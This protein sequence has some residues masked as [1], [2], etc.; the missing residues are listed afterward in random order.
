M[1]KLGLE[2]D[3]LT[4]SIVNT[5]SEKDFP[6]ASSGLSTHKKLSEGKILYIETDH[7]DHGGYIGAEIT[8]S[9]NHTQKIELYHS[10][11][12]KDEYWV[13][14]ENSASS[15]ASILDILEKDLPKA[16]P[17]NIK[18]TLDKAKANYKN[19]VLLREA[20]DSYIKSQ[21]SYAQRHRYV[22][23]PASPSNSSTTIQLVEYSVTGQTDDPVV[24]YEASYIAPVA[25]PNGER[26][27]IVTTVYRD[28]DHT[29]V[30]IRLIGD[31]D[32]QL[33]KDSRPMAKMY[34]KGLMI[35]LISIKS[36]I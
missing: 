23:E 9:N 14:P 8:D 19:P 30:S 28:Q 24:T 15:A 35:G 1:N 34:L 27:D 10:K 26:D 36:S 16:A 33:P 12:D 5:L 4:S 17:D 32:C 2:I 13:D 20:I 21:E 18:D 3:K 25:L 7:S 6:A 31:T 11:D 29:T 22:F